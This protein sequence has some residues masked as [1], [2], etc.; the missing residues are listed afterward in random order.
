MFSVTPAVKQEIDYA[1]FGL[2]ER[3]ARIE[4]GRLIELMEAVEDIPGRWRTAWLPTP[5]TSPTS[6]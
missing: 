3:I 1:D 6:T 4:L 2:N 5:S